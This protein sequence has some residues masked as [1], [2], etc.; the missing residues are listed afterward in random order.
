MQT[1]VGPA[2]GYS[3]PHPPSSSSSSRRRY[4]DNLASA[5]SRGLTANRRLRPTSRRRLSNATNNITVLI[6]SGDSPEASKRPTSL[7]SSVHLPRRPCVL[8]GSG[9][10]GAGSVTSRH[11]AVASSSPPR[12]H[13]TGTRRHRQQTQTETSEAGNKQRHERGFVLPASAACCTTAR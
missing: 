8:P 3:P 4:D 6:S 13:W 2:G 1:L 11:S 9:R 10:R 12:R 5:D 7:R